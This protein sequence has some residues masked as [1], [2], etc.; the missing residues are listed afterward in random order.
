MIIVHA[1]KTVPSFE[2]FLS[3]KKRSPCESDLKERN[4][5]DGKKMGISADLK[6]LKGLQN[7]KQYLEYLMHHPGN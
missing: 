2:K 6:L 1:G 5:A 4:D 7:D 3:Q